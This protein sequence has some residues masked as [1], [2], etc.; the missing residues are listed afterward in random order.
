[1]TNSARNVRIVVADD[2]PVVLLAI[3]DVIKAVPGFSIEATA[4]SGA[5]LLDILSKDSFDLIIT[6]FVMHQSEADEDGLRLIQRLKRLH[7]E[8]PIIVFTM[9]T[10]GG[11]LHQMCR[12][13]VGGLVGK[14]EK[15]NVLGEVCLRALEERHDND[16]Q[17]ILSPGIKARLANTGTTSEDF[18]RTQPLSPRELEVVRLFSRG[19]S[20]TEIAKGLN[21]SVPTVATQKR[22]AMRK[23]HIE[24]NAD[25]LR[26]AD[27]QGLS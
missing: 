19:L 16:R 5:E 8:I 10:N 18:Q 9:L 11:I 24:T 7:P 20:L 15:A 3:A 27:E 22:A 23:L 26:Y 13:G 4:H 2:H 1:M 17:T 21:R 25:L 6:D 12:I 14:D